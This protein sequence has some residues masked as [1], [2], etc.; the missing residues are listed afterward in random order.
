MNDVNNECT[1][2]GH[3]TLPDAATTDVSL[4]ESIHRTFAT[5]ESFF[6]TFN[7]TIASVEKKKLEEYDIDKLQEQIEERANCVDTVFT[8]TLNMR[9]NYLID[10]IEKDLTTD[11]TTVKSNFDIENHIELDSLPLFLPS[12]KTIYDCNFLIGSLIYCHKFTMLK[13]LKYMDYLNQLEYKTELLEELND[14]FHVRALILNINR[15]FIYLRSRDA[16]TFFKIFNNKCKELISIEICSSLVYKNILALN[17]QIVCLFYNQNQKYFLLS[18]Y[19]DELN[20]IKRKRLDF[21]C[22]LCSLSV[23]EIICWDT[24]NHK[25]VVYD[26]QLEQ[27]ANFGQIDQENEPFYFA[28]G[29]IIEASTRLILFYYYRE[30]NP[31]HYIKII[32]RRTGMTSGVINFDFDSFSKMIRIDTESNILF[33]SYD[34]SNQLKYY[35]STGKLIGLFSN[36]EFTKFSRID[37]TKS[38]ELIC[39]DKT[40]NKIFFL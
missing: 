7:R 1:A 34:P 13:K 28:D 27:I 30:T 26:F 15:V 36:N 11:L 16:K 37:L 33:K 9:R 21:D 12:K 23:N 4:H 32:D 5:L 19:D 10:Q 3:T 6:A 31:V 17:G 24:K 14:Y 29:V 40:D 8:K 2:E 39:F 38:D 22:N 35:D 18:V 25:C 20:I